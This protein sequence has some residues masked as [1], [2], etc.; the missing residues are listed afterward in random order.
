MERTATSQLRHSYVIFGIDPDV[1]VSAWSETGRGEDV[2]K[3]LPERAGKTQLCGFTGGCSFIVVVCCG[4]SL[5]D[6]TL[7]CD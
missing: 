2:T 5:H 4:C 3:P 6:W 7:T 1:Q